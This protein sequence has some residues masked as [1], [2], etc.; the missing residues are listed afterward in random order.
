MTR[1]DAH[2]RR[3]FNRI[4]IVEP[5]AEEYDVIGTVDDTGAGTDIGDISA[6]KPKRRS[7]RSKS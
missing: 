5:T 6:K 4:A 3:P 2:L 1:V 7:N